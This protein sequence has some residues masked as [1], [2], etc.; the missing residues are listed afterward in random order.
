MQI[1]C[2][3]VTGNQEETSYP[4]SCQ[5]WKERTEKNKRQRRQLSSNEN[6]VPESEELPV[7]KVPS[8][9]DVRFLMA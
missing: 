2:D 1:N 8:Y 3:K 5:R 9:V 4:S 6:E 7:L